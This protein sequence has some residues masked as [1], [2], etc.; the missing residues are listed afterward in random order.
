MIRF[1]ALVMA[2]AVA[3]ATAHAIN[4]MIRTRRN[5]SRCSM[6]VM[7]RSSSAGTI[8]GLAMDGAS[9]ARSL[10]GLGVGGR[11]YVGGRAFGR[12][13]IDRRLRGAAAALDVLLQIGGGLAELAHRLADG[14]PHFGKL[15][16]PVHDQHDGEHDDQHVPVTE[17][18]HVQAP[19]AASLYARPGAP[20]SSAVARLAN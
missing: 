14:T 5:S 18:R 13:G 7:R 6:T 15:S 17:E 3:I 11:L 16:G 12:P 8:F 19:F 10:G 1:K 9:G 2:S 20:L 4:E